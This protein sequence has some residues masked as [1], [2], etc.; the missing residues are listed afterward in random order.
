M[1]CFRAIRIPEADRAPRPTRTRALLETAPSASP[2]ISNHPGRACMPPPTRTRRASGGRTAPWC[3]QW[4]AR[5]SRSDERAAPDLSKSDWLAVATGWAAAIHARRSLG[6]ARPGHGVPRAGSEPAV[7]PPDAPRTDGQRTQ[8][9]RRHRIRGDE[10]TGPSLRE[11]ERALYPAS[12]SPNTAVF[13]GGACSSLLLHARRECRTVD[14]AGFRSG[15]RGDRSRMASARYRS[16]P[17]R[18]DGTIH[19]ADCPSARKQ[20]RRRVRS[21][22][23]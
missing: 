6:P 21:T 18:R 22:V 2:T 23:R 7:Y 1:R 15:G 17:R 12:R 4:R 19:G 20:R 16:R 10:R 14:G 3:G 9:R 8:A 5:R 13:G 11:A